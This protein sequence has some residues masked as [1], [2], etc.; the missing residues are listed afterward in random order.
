[1]NSSPTPRRSWPI[2]SLGVLIFLSGF[3]IFLPLFI[4]P[5]FERIYVDALGPD[6]PLPGITY[7]IIGARIPLALI[8]L[9]WPVLAI[10]AVQRRWRATGWIINLG[11]L[12]FFVL[13]G[14]TVIALFMPMV[15]DI[16]GMSDASLASPA[17]SH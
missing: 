15:G 11:Y 17:A 13:I 4:V 6:H 12:F 9:A 5:K 7:F 10:I 2:F 3:N 8:A 16:T 1:M 14:L